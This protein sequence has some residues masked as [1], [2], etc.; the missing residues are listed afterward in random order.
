MAC[1]SPRSHS[2]P[3]RTGTIRYDTARHPPHLSPRRCAMRRGWEWGPSLGRGRFGGHEALEPG[4][5]VLQPQHARARMAVARE[6]VRL[7]LEADQAHLAAQILEG[8]V[9]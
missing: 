4:D 7:A 8:G 2:P 5:D 6:I 9:H 3:A 1:V